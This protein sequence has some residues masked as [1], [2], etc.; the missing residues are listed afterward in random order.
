MR[1]GYQ[2]LP[3]IPTYLS[4]GTCEESLLLL[5]KDDLLRAMFGKE[6]LPVISIIPIVT[7][8]KRP[9]KVRFDLKSTQFR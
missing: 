7:T 6:Q 3:D 4:N 8:P 5:S 2:T 9:P 1:F